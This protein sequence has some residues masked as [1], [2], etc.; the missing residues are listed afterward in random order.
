M[1]T[2]VR[3]SS[4][5]SP[6]ESIETPV[7]RVPSSPGI[8]EKLPSNPN[9]LGA[10]DSRRHI[11]RAMTEFQTASQPSSAIIIRPLQSIILRV[12]WPAPSPPLAWRT[13][14]TQVWQRKEQPTQPTISRCP[15]IAHHAAS[16]GGSSS[17][18]ITGCGHKLNVTIYNI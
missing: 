3:H 2:R 7:G 14:T 6:G 11:K 13:L 17:E 8:T 10:P 5:C 4:C 16:G 9:R 1:R 15:G 18:R 12:L